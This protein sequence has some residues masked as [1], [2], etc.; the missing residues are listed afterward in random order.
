M[1][2]TVEI[3]DL[4]DQLGDGGKS[5]Q[6]MDKLRRQLELENEELQAA[7]EEAE[8]SLEQEEAKVTRAQLE[9]VTVKEEIDR[10]LAEKD[11]ELESTRCVCRYLTL[12]C[13]T[14][15]RNFSQNGTLCVNG[16][17][18]FTVIFRNNPFH[19]LIFWGNLKVRGRIYILNTTL[20]SSG[21]GEFHFLGGP[22]SRLDETLFILFVA[23]LE[24]TDLLQNI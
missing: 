8:G 22:L 9:L 2:F 11:E 19:P 20:L 24:F 17:I 12:I 18:K 21:L 23:L 5:V 14:F 1:L 15:F 10:R 13:M 7:L 3:H 4:T 6:E 16:L